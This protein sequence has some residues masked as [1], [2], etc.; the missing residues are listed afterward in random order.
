MEFKPA[1]TDRFDQFRVELRVPAEVKP[2]GVDRAG[3]PDQFFGGRRG[4]AGGAVGAEPA[5]I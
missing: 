1:V 4:T 5:Q 2:V 3:Q